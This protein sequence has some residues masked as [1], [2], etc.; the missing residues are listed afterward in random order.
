MRKRNDNQGFTRART[1]RIIGVARICLLLCAGHSVHAAVFRC[2][3]AN[4]VNTYADRPC[5]PNIS[6]KVGQA[7]AP[8]SSDPE[9]P[10][11]SAKSKKAARIL[12]LLH[13]APSEPETFLL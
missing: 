6:E 10:L 13:I 1:G 8:A 12:D 2:V 5:A 7:G 9:P 4:G 11:N 3:D